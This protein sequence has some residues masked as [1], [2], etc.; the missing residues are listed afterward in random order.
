MLYGSGLA[1]LAKPIL[2]SLIQVYP[3]SQIVDTLCKGSDFNFYSPLFCSVLECYCYRGLFLQALNVYLKAKE[4]GHSSNSALSCNALLNLLQ[5]KNE[6][7]LAWCFYGSMIRNGV[8]ENQFTWSTIGRILCKDG[9]FERIVRILDMGIHNSVMYNLIIECHSGRGSF[10][11]ALGYLAEMGNRNLDPSFSTYASI[12]EGAC[13]YQNAELIE[14]IFQIMIENGHVSKCFTNL[15]YDALIQKLSDLG[16]SYAA[17]MF[18]QRACN[19]KVE[20]QDATYGC[21]LRAFSHG[22]R[23]KD[24]TKLYHMVL[25]KKIEMKDSCY[26]AYVKLLCKQKPSTEVCQLLKDIIEKGFPPSMAELSKYIKSVCEKFWWKAAEE[27]LNLILDRGFLPDSYCY[28]SLVKHYCFIGW[29]HSAINLHRKLEILDGSFDVNTYDM[30]LNE[31]LRRDKREEAQAIFNY[32]RKQKM[33][34][35]ESFTVMIIGFC[36]AK[37][38]RTAMKL[39]DEMLS[40]GLKPEKKTYKSLISG[41]G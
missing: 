36:R 28:C 34:G 20:L 26:N 27:L 6:I 10:E 19:D 33:L 40:L 11:A 18:F 22:G 37:E 29:I 14:M 12:L 23:M 41:F 13:K 39:H 1:R 32:M 25:E 17:E 21:M 16:K 2:D 38:L 31:L 24:A 8:V 35:T 9:K 30:L 3:S 15:E 4:L 5:E 7:R